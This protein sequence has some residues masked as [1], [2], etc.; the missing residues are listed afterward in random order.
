MKLIDIRRRI[1]QS[2][3]G[4]T[5]DSASEA[6]L[7][8]SELYSIDPRDIPL[9]LFDDFEENAEVDK[10]IERRRNGEPLEYIF[11]KAV[12]CGL[13][14]SVSCDC[15]IPQ[16]DTEVVVEAA[17]SHL[18]KGSRFAD[19][20]T[21]SGC[22]AVSIAKFSGASGIAVDISAKALEIAAKNAES[23]GVSSQINFINADILKSEDYF[24][25][26]YD[27]IVSNPPYIPTAECDTLDPRVK[28]H[29]PRNALDGG[30][31]GLDFYER[32]VGDAMNVLKPGGA[33]FFEIGDGQGDA[34]RELFE[35]YGFAGATVER[36]FAGRERY[37]FARLG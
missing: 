30:V 3:S 2:L 8:V 19:L 16:A 18:S 29:E 11:G 7:I 15:L 21:G 23:N 5:P 35:A 4:V 13:D 28:D 36:D 37:A 10:V 17:R 6:L 20:C 25:E 14:F 22:I 27:V 33:L 34:L 9:K 26:K 12:F 31:S 24:D 1:A 32:F